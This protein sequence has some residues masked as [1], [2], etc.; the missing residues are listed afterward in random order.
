MA[1]K[2]KGGKRRPNSIKHITDILKRSI[3]FL[4]CI[5]LIGT[6]IPTYMILASNEDKEGIEI[7]EEGIFSMSLESLIESTENAVTDEEPLSEEIYEFSGSC[8]DE[9]EKLFDTEDGLLYEIYPELDEE[10][11]SLTL[12]TFVRIKKSYLKEELADSPKSA[13]DGSEA[14]NEL[15]NPEED[16]EDGEEAEEVESA[17]SSDYNVTGNEE[18]I[19]LLINDSDEE[20]ST[21]IL[22]TASEDEVYETR[23]ITVPG[24][25]DKT[26]ITIN[27]VESMSESMSD[28]VYFVIDEKQENMNAASLRVESGSDAYE[29][30]SDP[31]DAGNAEKTGESEEPEGTEDTEYAEYTEEIKDEENAVSVNAG[32]SAITSAVSGS[33]VNVLAESASNASAS[34]YTEVCVPMK[35]ELYGSV[36]ADGM[37]AVAIVTTMKDLGFEGSLKTCSLVYEGT[38]Y[39]VTV[40]YDSNAGIPEDAELTGEE[41][42]TDSERYIE[43][44]EEAKE[45]YGWENGSE[46]SVRLFDV[47]LIL[48]GKEIEPDAPVRVTFIFYD[49][50]DEDEDAEAIF[51]SDGADQDEDK[52]AEIDDNKED[53]ESADDQFFTITHF[54]I[55]GTEVVKSETSY[56]D[57]GR[58]VTFT[59]NSL[60]DIMV[61]ANSDVTVVLNLGNIYGSDGKNL[62]YADENTHM[63]YS[64]TIRQGQ[65][66]DTVTVYL[67]DDDAL[68]S[69]FTVGY[70]Q[71]NQAVNITLG[72]EWAYDYRLVGWFDIATGEYYDVSEGPTTAEV[73]TSGYHVFYADWIAAD[74]DQGTPD[75]DNANLVETV[76]TSS[77]VT[78]KL[79]DFNELFNMYST[80]LSQTDTTSEIWGFGLNNS[81]DGYFYEKPYLKETYVNNDTDN[82]VVAQYP[83][84][85]FDSS[86]VITGNSLGNVSGRGNS[87]PNRWIAA[88]IP[89]ASTWGIDR[90]DAPI[91]VQIFNDDNENNMVGVYYVGEGNYLFQY[92]TQEKEGQSSDTEK[93]VGYYY[94]ESDLNSAVYNQTDGRFYVYDE[95]QYMWSQGNDQYTGFLPFNKYKLDESERYDDGTADSNGKSHIYYDIYGT[96]NYWFGMEMEVNFYLPGAVGVKENGN[97][98]NMVDGKE[99]TF[100]FSGDDDIMVFVDDDL[101]LDMSGIHNSFYGSINFASG[102]VTIED[103]QGED[104]SPSDISLGA[105]THT[106]TVYYMER[107]AGASNLGVSF[108]VTPLWKYETG[109]LQSIYAQKEW[110]YTNGESVPEEI[111]NNCPAVWFGLFEEMEYEYDTATGSY[112][113]TDDHTYDGTNFIGTSY[114]IGSDGYSRDSDGLIDAVLTEEGKLYVRVD[115]HELKYQEDPGNY[116]DPVTGEPTNFYGWYYTWECLEPEGNYEVLELIEN[117]P[118]T[119]ASD[120]TSSE[121]G[122]YYWTIIG[123]SE[124]ESVL[125]TDDYADDYQV[126]LTNA[127]QDAEGEADSNGKATGYII[128]ADEQVTTKEATFS[129]KAVIEETIEGG[130][131]VYYGTYGAVTGETV[132]GLEGNAVWNIEK[133]EIEVDDIDR[134]SMLHAFRLYYTDENGQNHYLTEGDQKSDGTYS[135]TTTYDKDS[136]YDFYD[137]ALGELR[138]HNPKTDASEGGDLRVCFDSENGEVYVTGFSEKM[139]DDHH[140]IK[141][142]SWNQTESSGYIFTLTNTINPDLTIEKNDET[143]ENTL[144]GA[145]FILMKDVGDIRYYYSYDP[146]DEDTEDGMQYYDWVTDPDEATVVISDE[147]GK[148]VFRYIGDGTY[149]LEEV[150]APDGYNMLPAA[151]QITITTVDNGDG[152]ERREIVFKWVDEPEDGR[153][154]PDIEKYITSSDDG[155]T[156]IV[157]NNP[158]SELPETGGFGTSMFTLTGLFLMSGSA[159]LYLTLK[160]RKM[161]NI[162]DSG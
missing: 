47:S 70:N 46:P 40:E 157:K 132:T 156:I 60:S 38:D 63:R 35:G 39:T 128:V 140:N 127:A 153:E 121:Y 1:E 27:T 150:K 45:L 129:Q 138:I 77:F 161:I 144:A 82:P 91:L 147:D 113:V 48:D 107:G 74:Y 20:I 24:N 130:I 90:P 79:F 65:S 160:R 23:E 54:G 6:N 109:T 73:S 76:D 51:L 34:S 146:D 131:T 5:C 71:N 59:L 50:D 88:N 103:Y 68:G 98:V 43:R 4:V 118:Y 19:F 8:A 17:L 57:G 86:G 11:D 12:R 78:V 14:D 75:V 25:R 33:S 44:F 119:S 36:N 3:V 62:H 158:G 104:H 41:Y 125:A 162:N 61:L 139:E 136:A 110:H 26:N 151:V 148:A 108:N 7:P 112:F 159:L 94:Y 83:M 32:I 81:G 105:G 84:T 49:Y 2:S 126:I 123:E 145:E 30:V 9:Y 85:V 102:K 10:C 122:F 101:V 154:L 42:E 149:I 55:Y 22:V 99:M 53:S 124:I 117:A 142:Y 21:R 95:P 96:T 89:G 58:S 137:D 97:Y 64:A 92:G 93:Y 135:L 72:K 18:I 37:K 66:N 80:K 106:L 152:T 111:T 120:E 116:L 133:T 141:V 15:E 69:T 28:A 114:V 115:V 16:A 56:G 13:K 87:D 29:V 100:N 31:E 52:D 67:P 134:S 143:G 155:F